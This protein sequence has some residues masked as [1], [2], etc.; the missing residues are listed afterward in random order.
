MRAHLRIARPVSD[1]ALATA[2]YCS[3]LDFVVID[4]FEDHQGFDGVM[5]G[6]LGTGYHFEFT[7]SR[8]HLVKPNPTIEDLVVLYL[9]DP[10]DW[11]N[12][13]AKMIT[14]GFERVSSFNP[15]WESHGATFQDLDGYRV[16]LQNDE[17]R[18]DEKP[19]SDGNSPNF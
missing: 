7:H 16:V 13:C 1:I 8:N 11:K 15:Y 10:L 5:L 2:M 18:N 9:P 4:S 14:A 3:G 19:L 17:W 6:Y 12:A